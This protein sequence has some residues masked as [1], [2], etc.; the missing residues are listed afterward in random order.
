M[1]IAVVIGGYSSESR[2]SFQSGIYILNNL[3]KL[4]YKKYLVKISQRSWH[5]IT[6]EINIPID[7]SN[8][9]FKLNKKII[10]FDVILNTIHGSPGE[11]GQ[12]QAYWNL[13]NIPFSGSSFYASALTFN[14]QDTLTI[15]SK[16]KFPTIKSI[17]IKNNILINYESIQKEIN[18]PFIV[19]PNRSGSSLGISKVEKKSDFKKAL[20]YAI[21]EDKEILCQTFLDGTE[22]SV[23][24]FEK[25]GKINI[26][27]ITEIISENSFFD[28]DAKYLKK[29]Q[30]ITPA[31]ISKSIK[32][33]I[34]KL[35]IKAY[36]IFSLN[37]FVRM[38]FIIQNN[39]I[40]YLIEINTTPGLSEESIFPKQI[41]FAKLNFSNLLEI[42]IN[43][44]LNKKMI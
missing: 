12:M 19:K 39:K 16:N 33:Q 42:E 9:S 24:V 22:V 17:H 40:P 35:T 44:I 27:G 29:S 37:G 1:N 11:D 32:K 20:K 26:L 43:R 3:N 38:D 31:R 21:I 8:F 4:I 10:K 18:I 28:Y 13:L 15:L 30:E 23:G 7:K 6:K 2:V 5:V 14:K 41:K 36:N 34:E 25:L